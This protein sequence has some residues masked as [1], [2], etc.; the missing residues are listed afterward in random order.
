MNN[1]SQ[2]NLQPHSSQNFSKLYI[3]I[4]NIN[5]RYETISLHDGTVARRL[6]G[7]SKHRNDLQAGQ[8]HGAAD[9]MLPPCCELRAGTENFWV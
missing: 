9:Q 3:L 8:T 4:E 2:G 6:G 5:P 7:A 1:Y